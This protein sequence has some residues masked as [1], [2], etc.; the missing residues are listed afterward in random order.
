MNFFEQELRKIVEP[1]D[2]DAA[3]VGRSAYLNLG[4]G[5]RAKLSFVTMGI[6]DQYAG[7]KMSVVNLRDGELDANVLRFSD[8]F[9]KKPTRNPNF[10]EGIVPHIWTDRGKSAWYVYRPT[11]AD[12]A[13]LTDRVGEYISVFQ[14]ETQTQGQ[15]MSQ[16]PFM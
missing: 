1:I 12:Y 16:S 2:H 13:L 10:R 15:S 4:G 7:L 11:D 3:Y 5:N 14:D 6:A 8:L 9:G